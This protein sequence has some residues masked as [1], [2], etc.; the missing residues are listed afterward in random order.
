MKAERNAYGYASSVASCSVP[1][2]QVRD[3]N[4]KTGF[5]QVYGQAVGLA[6]GQLLR[7]YN[8]DC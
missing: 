3:L 7:E 8:R 5:R 1:P 2:V 6:V 4:S